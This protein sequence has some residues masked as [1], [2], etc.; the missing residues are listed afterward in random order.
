MLVHECGHM[1]SAILGG[2]SIIDV[3]LRPWKLSHTLIA[4][5]DHQIMDAWMGPIFGAVFPAL[6]FLMLK[7]TRLKTILGF[8]AGFCLVGNGV[9]IGIGWLGPYGDAEVMVQLGVPVAI[10]I[11]FGL[12]AS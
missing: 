6:L 9:Y 11:T 1:L 5:S 2:A 10:M 8:F 4:D 7:Q 3:E 12:V